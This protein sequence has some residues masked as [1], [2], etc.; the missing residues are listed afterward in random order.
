MTKKLKRELI[1]WSVFIAV[2]AGLYLT[3]WHTEVLGTLQRGVL[4]SGLITPDIEEEPGDKMDFRF[5]LKSLDGEDFDARTLEGEVVFI[6]L[7]AT[8]CPPCIAE[9]PDIHDLYLKKGQQVKFVMI[10]LDK[11]PQKAR[12]FIKRKEFEFPVYTADYGLPEVLYTRSIPTTFVISRTGDIVVKRLGLA[13]YNNQEF[14][15]YLDGLV[16]Q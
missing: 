11:D 3:G 10:S 14:I 13:Q 5:Q 12:D 9:M 2:I 15:E 4:A 7:W 1:E 8:W 6:N 16:S